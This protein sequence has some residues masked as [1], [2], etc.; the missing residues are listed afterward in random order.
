M[1]PALATFIELAA[2]NNWPW[3]VKNPPILYLDFQVSQM[4]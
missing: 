1:V 3:C 2:Y 4:T